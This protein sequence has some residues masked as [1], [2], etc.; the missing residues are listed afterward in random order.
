MINLFK[1]LSSLYIMANITEHFINFVTFRD[2][3]NEMQ[4]DICLFYI[5][6]I[7]LKVSS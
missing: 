1:L 7:L 2:S 4:R 6:H 3:V 5:C